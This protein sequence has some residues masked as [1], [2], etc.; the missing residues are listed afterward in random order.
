M[1]TYICAGGEYGSALQAAAFWGHLEIIK[2]LLDYNTDVNLHGN[3]LITL[4]LYASLY[5]GR[6]RIWKCTSSSNISEK[7]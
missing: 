4:E 7:P 2:L 5:L 3:E 6:W 1:L